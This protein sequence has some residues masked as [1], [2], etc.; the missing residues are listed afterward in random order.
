MILYEFICQDCQEQFEDLV[1]SIDQ[2]ILCP[3]CKSKNVKRLLSAVKNRASS[4]ASG[5]ERAA[6]CAPG[7]EF[8]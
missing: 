4:T 1:S 3:K 2:E 6:A 5:T 7:A 8:S